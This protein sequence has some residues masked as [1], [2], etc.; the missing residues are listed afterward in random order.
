MADEPFFRCPTESLEHHEPTASH[1][2]PL[3]T[4]HP[5]LRSTPQ[6]AV[7]RWRARGTQTAENSS[8]NVLYAGRCRE[9]QVLKTTLSTRQGER[10]L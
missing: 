7:E 6:T 1:V 8:F 5:R 9:M 4:G 10:V 3:T 2:V